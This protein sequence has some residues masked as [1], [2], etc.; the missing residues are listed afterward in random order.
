MQLTFAMQ[1]NCSLEIIEAARG[2]FWYC[3]QSSGWFVH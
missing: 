1:L 3:H 2:Q